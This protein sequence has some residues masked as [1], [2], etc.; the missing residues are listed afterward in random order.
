[1]THI[2]NKDSSRAGVF[3]LLV[4]VPDVIELRHEFS[5]G[6]AQ[7]LQLGLDWLIFWKKKQ[8]LTCCNYVSSAN[9]N[10]NIEDDENISYVTM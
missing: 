5:W 10:N 3:P 7:Q 9:M 2:E 8:E 6:G 4:L 1:M